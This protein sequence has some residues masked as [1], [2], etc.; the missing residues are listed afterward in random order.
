[1]LFLSWPATGGE[2]MAT[3]RAGRW[4]DRA[5]TQLHLSVVN[6]VCHSA[7]STAGM[8]RWACLEPL[9]RHGIRE[10]LNPI[11]EGRSM[12]RTILS[13]FYYPRNQGHH[14]WTFVRRWC[15]SRSQP[16][17]QAQQQD[18]NE[19]GRA[20]VSTPALPASGASPR[21]CAIA[22]GKRGFLRPRSRVLVESGSC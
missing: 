2:M 21:A 8:D 7:K 17:R 14:G 12:G 20:S 3:S 13:N 6:G 18:S 22:R 19:P 5:E 16:F 15:A 4:R 9:P 10:P 11:I 1:L